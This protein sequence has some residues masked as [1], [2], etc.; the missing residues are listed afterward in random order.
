MRDYFIFGGVDSRT[1]NAWIFEEMTFNGVV[2]DYEEQVVPGR[3]GTLMLDNHR[4]NNVE[5]IYHVVIPAS[6]ETNYKNFR[7]ALSAQRGYQRLTDS[8]HTDEFY[9]AVINF[10]DGLEPEMTIERGMGHFSVSFYRKPQRFLTSGETVTTLTASGTITNPTLFDAKPLMRVY[11][12]GTLGIGSDSIQITAAD[13][14]TDIDFDIMEAYKGAVSCND[15]IRLTSVDYPVLPAG[16]TAI[17]LG[18]GITKVEITPRWWR[19]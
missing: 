12:T 19:V 8:L 18:T 3:Y 9:M 13:S 14:Y 1:Y 15:K 2:Q 16:N 11:G 4:A 6:F 17:S 5:H 10:E 7:A